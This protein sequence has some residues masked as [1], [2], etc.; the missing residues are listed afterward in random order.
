[1][2]LGNWDFHGNFF[3]GEIDVVIVSYG[4]KYHVA[5]CVFSGKIR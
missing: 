1:L 4:D 2:L 5:V 3:C